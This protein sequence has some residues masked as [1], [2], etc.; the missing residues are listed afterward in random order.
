[1]Q[2]VPRAGPTADRLFACSVAREPIEGAGW[3]AR[4][5]YVHRITVCYEPV[6]LMGRAFTIDDANRL[7]TAL[8]TDSAEGDL[9]DNGAVDRQDWDILEYWISTIDRR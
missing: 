4:N 2:Q 6:G 8:L 1:M 7:T 3:S 9:N 5:A